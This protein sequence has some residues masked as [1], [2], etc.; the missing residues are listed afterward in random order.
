MEYATW[1]PFYE[2]IAREFGFA[3]EREERSAHRLEA[4]LPPA[5]RSE[6]LER[7]RARLH[8][9]EVIVVGSAPRSGPPPLWRLPATRLAPAIIAADGATAECVDAGI[10][11]T[12][13]TT[14]LDG[15]IPVE[16]TANRR[17]S[18][19]VVHAHGD[20]L[21]A[22]EE[23]VTQF[24]GELAGT[25][26]GPP[27]ATLVNVGGFTDGD[28][29]VFLAEDAGAASILLWGFDF[30]SAEERTEPERARKLAKLAWAERL[31][32]ELARTGRS[33]I[34][35][36]ERDGTIRP[37]PPGKSDASTR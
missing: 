5:A 33:P 15:P 35:V 28:R 29:A 7:M 14:D 2:R 3:F 8:G 30:R 37:Y 17:G 19:V 36:W 32:G 1:A 31:I 21:R 34:R 13:I 26:A 4:L 20:N 9:R 18:L 24:P 6:P 16:I 22:L 12:M 11:P 25:W 27:R 23:W 10:V